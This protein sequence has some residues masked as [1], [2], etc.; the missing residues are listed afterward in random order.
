MMFGEIDSPLREGILGFN[1]GDDA[2][3]LARRASMY[4]K[5]PVYVYL[6]PAYKKYWVHDISPVIMGKP[7]PYSGC[8][9]ILIGETRVGMSRAFR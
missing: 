3:A 2:F 5:R 1:D 8:Q 4:H 6:D 9:L 7:M